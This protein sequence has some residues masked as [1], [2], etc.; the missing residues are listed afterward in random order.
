MKELQDKILKDGVILGND[1]LVVGR[2]LNQNVD[3]HLLKHMAEEVKK[4]FNCHVDRV[5]TAEA[6]GIPFATAVA[7]EYGCDMLF[8]KKTVSSNL[9]GNI[10]KTTIK[11]YTRNTET[12]LILNKDYVNPGEKVLIV[13]DFLALGSASTALL[14]LAKKASL[15]VVG[16]SFCVEKKYQNGGNKLRELGYDCFSLASI[17]YMDK[18]KIMFN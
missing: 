15:D 7:M 17:E 13:D 16:F 3:I 12:T 5:L 2:F 8:A 18:E 4:H 11:S 10:V 14:D 9:S 6:S 1:I